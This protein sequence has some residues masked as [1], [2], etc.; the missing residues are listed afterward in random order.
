[1]SKF[2]INST[3]EGVDARHPNGLT[4]KSA[5]LMDA[6]AGFWRKHLGLKR[7]GSRER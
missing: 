4:S 6:I 1:M 2:N 3:L 7:R 5:P